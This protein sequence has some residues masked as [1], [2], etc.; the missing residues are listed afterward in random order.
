MKKD[1][2]FSKKGKGNAKSKYFTGKVSMKEVSRVIKPREQKIYHVTFYGSKTKLHQHSGGQILIVTKG[3]GI[4]SRY[5]KTS[6]SK[7][8]KTQQTKLGA[9]DIVYIPANQLH[10]HGAIDHRT[11]FSHIALN[12]YH[13]NKAPKTTWYESDFKSVI[14]KTIR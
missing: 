6:K 9:G 7:I 4:L 5:K 13:K 14:T 2:I 3:R 12:S 1:N 8:K 10:T 11:Q